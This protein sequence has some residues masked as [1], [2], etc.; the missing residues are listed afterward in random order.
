MSSVEGPG[1]ARGLLVSLT[2]PIKKSINIIIGNYSAPKTRGVM[3]FTAKL[4]S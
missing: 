2:V 1:F 4:F 3:F